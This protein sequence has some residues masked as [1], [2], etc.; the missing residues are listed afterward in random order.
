MAYSVAYQT[1]IAGCVRED[2][3][4]F[5]GQNKV[6]CGRV[7]SFHAMGGVNQP[8]LTKDY[9]NTEFVG[10]AGNDVPVIGA[11]TAPNIRIS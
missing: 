9:M 11:Y 3:T 1:K 10:K 7:T 8:T 5:Y 6:S 4:S 2:E